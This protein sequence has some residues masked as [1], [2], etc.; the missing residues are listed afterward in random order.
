[1]TTKKQSQ[2]GSWESV[3]TPE[4]IIEGGLRF[5]EIRID[6]QDIYFLEGRPSES[7]RSVII[8]HNQDGTTTDII[9]KKFNSRN[10]VHEY[11]GG[12][13]TVKDEIVF[14]TNWEDQ[15]IYKV[16]ADKI[17][18]ITEPSDIPMGIRYADLTLSNDSKW[19]FCVRETHIKDKEA[20]NEIV[21]VSTISS[22]IIVL[23]SGRDFYSSPR[24]NPIS[25][26][27]CWLEWD[28]PNM[29]WDGNELYIAG[30]DSQKI[31]NKLKIDGSTNISIVQPEWTDKGELIYIS[32][33]SGWW[34]LKKYSDQKISDILS[35]EIDH[36]GPA[37]Q[38][39]FRTYFIYE[40]CIFLKGSLNDKN[41]GLIRKI[42]LSGEIIEEIQINHTSI[43]DLSLCNDN[44][45]YIG[46]SP[47]TSSQVCSLDLRSSNLDI[48]KE[49]NTIYIDNEEISIAEEIIFDTTS[50]DISYAYFY[51]PTNKKFEGLKNEKPPLLVISHGGPTGS[52]SNSLNL[53]VQYWTNRGFAVVDVNYRGSTGYGRKY[54]DAL[55]GNW[56]VYDTDDCIAAVDFL[57]NRGLVDSSRV[58][59]KGGSAGG[60]TTIN[61]LTFHKRFA[62]GATYYGIA[63][64]SVFIADT[65]KFE[66]RYL[67]ALIGKYP[68]EK[69]KYY[70][71]SAINFTDQLSCPMIIF[72]GTEDKIVPPS[73]A[74]IMAQGLRD[75]KIPFS[76][77]MYEG[78]QHGFRKSENIK[79]SLESE[80]FFYSKVLKFTAFDK[81]NNIKIENSDRL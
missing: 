72:Q 4:K 78:E 55:K 62:V 47:T 25:N 37:W 73:Q 29:P 79:S 46:A 2:Y 35:E 28:H 18:P 63:D 12:S 31:S 74:E 52:T 8:K 61:A 58:A 34:N 40:D 33:D 70:N 50:N 38:F 68:E 24:P 16:S 53:S 57:S 60:Y 26:Q 15:L 56:G 3:F 5:N 32:D 80:L 36:G 48:L 39:G 21:A 67:D 71:R 22:E 45:I 59:I 64:L 49:S 27:I 43:S 51:K 14:F 30:F 19:I 1:M 6:N 11:G 76:L 77:I 81:L 66:S 65:H 75:K 20:Q 69:E 41:K 42:S 54:R 17:T 44:A 23:A 10:A 13:F 9:P 7:G